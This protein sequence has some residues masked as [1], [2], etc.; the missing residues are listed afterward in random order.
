[1]KAYG[2]GQETNDTPATVA[3]L[4]Q[5]Q[6]DRAGQEQGGTQE[7]DG[8]GGRRG[9]QGR[10]R[11]GG[12]AGAEGINTNAEQFGAIGYLVRN[13]DP[14]NA[15]VVL[16]VFYLIRP[17][18]NRIPFFSVDR[19]RMLVVPILFGMLLGYT[20]EFSSRGLQIWIVVRRGLAAGCTASAA[21][22]FIR[23]FFHSPDSTYAMDPD[24]RQPARTMAV[25]HV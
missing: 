20:A 2:A 8:S 3:F 11:E 19:N 25:K 13:A 9:R 5:E 15:V 6:G 22:W 14:L 1:M 16:V 7:Q 4:T 10:G 24:P 17:L 23:M 21:I 18:L 12:G